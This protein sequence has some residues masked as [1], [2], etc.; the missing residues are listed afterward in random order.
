MDSLAK[1]SSRRDIRKA[2]ENLPKEL[3]HTYDEAMQRI[4]SQDEDDIK[5]AEQVLS[6]LSFTFRPLTMIEIQHVLA[7]EPG[8]VDFDEDALLDED[9][10]V[11]VCAGLVTVDQES[12]V[13]RLVH[14][15]TQEYFE[16]TRTSLFPNAQTNIA[17]SCLVYLSLDA[18][19]ESYCK[20]E[21]EIRTRMRTYPFL[22]Y[23][24]QH[25]GNHGRGEAEESIKELALEFL[26]NKSKL[27]CATQVMHISDTPHLVFDNV[28]FESIVGL[29]LVASLGLSKIVHLLLERE[30]VN[31]N[32]KDSL[33]RTPLLLAV[34]GG[35]ETV[36]QQLLE[37]EDIDADSK[38]LQSQ[39][40]LWLA[41]AKGHQSIVRLL[42]EH[43]GI[44]ANFKDRH[45]RTP[46]SIA[47]ET[48]HMAVV[49]FLL[50]HEDVDANSTDEYSRTPLLKA[51][52]E[53]HK[54]VVQLLLGH[55]GVDADLKDDFG[56]T[57]LSR[58]SEKGREGVVRLLLGCNN[59]NV[60]SKDKDGQASLS[61]AAA[62]GYEPLV[63]L[64]LEQKDVDSDSKDEYGQTPL[65][66]AS[67]KGHEAV[68]RLLLDCNN[69]NINSKDKDGQ[70][71]LWWATVGGHKTVV[72]L[73][74]QHAGVAEFGA[75]DAALQD[76]S[77]PEKQ[78]ATSQNS[79]LDIDLDSVID[80][81]LEI[82]GCRPGKQVQLLEAE[83]YYLCRKAREIFLSQPM[84][85]ELKAP[86]KVC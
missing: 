58:A 5:V 16:R 42:L 4:R 62:G 2:L 75:V 25:W 49:G 54:E 73:L 81:L 12:N 48:G 72:T 37:R 27:M 78:E 74:S 60:N 80:R 70:T 51:A 55:N 61:W 38:D 65:S 3:D 28:L 67:E 52:G 39:T 21:K 84:L 6:W 86:I 68:V 77:S 59:V 40:P 46:L 57:P 32:S 1:K 53:G 34:E 63:K 79:L 66:R 71:P 22:E 13:I 26:Q 15:T 20:N 24:V 56:Q 30:D 47:A 18:F 7:V 76:H 64:L 41:S 14:H 8:D 11:S 10:L 35:H 44:N 9:V 23:A 33:G 83:I 69:I 31:I 82:R 29:H 50:K 17:T 36:V 85:L 43:K 19:A 45:G